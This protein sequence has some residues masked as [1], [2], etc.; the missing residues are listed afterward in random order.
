LKNPGESGLLRRLGGRLLRWWLPYGLGGLAAGVLVALVPSLLCRAPGF[1]VRWLLPVAGAVA[2]LSAGLFWSLAV[3][4]ERLTDAIATSLFGRFPDSRVG[5]AGA[6]GRQLR[7]RVAAPARLL[8]LTA[9][10]LMGLV[11]T[12]ATLTVLLAP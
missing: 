6:L 3:A 11:A 10:L 2:G 7:R 1:F 9:A 8:R 12:A 5:A 4:T